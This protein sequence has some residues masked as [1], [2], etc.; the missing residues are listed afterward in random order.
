MACWYVRTKDKLSPVRYGLLQEVW[1]IHG[2]LT[3]QKNYLDCLLQVAKNQMYI[4]GQIFSSH[5]M[6]E[7]FTINVW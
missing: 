4:F 2:S 1:K 5:E 6:I 3:E 7:F